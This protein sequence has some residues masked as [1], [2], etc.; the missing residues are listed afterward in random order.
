MVRSNF[1]VCKC[2]HTRT[3][4]VLKVCKIVAFKQNDKALKFNSMTKINLFQ[5]NKY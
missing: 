4:V 2:F 5:N 3:K 1:C